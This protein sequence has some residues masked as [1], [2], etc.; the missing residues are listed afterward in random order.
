MIEKLK[1]YKETKYF[2][3]FSAPKEWT[4]KDIYKDPIQ[5]DLAI[6]MDELYDEDLIF[7]SLQRL[8]GFIYTLK[9]SIKIK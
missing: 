1:L 8:G 3:I 4:G 7:L 6:L 2:K 9:N 5:S